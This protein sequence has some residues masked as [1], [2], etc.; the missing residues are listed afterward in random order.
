MY[1]PNAFFAILRSTVVLILADFLVLLVL[2]AAETRAGN[3][4]NGEN[5]SVVLKSY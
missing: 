2:T 5:A 1:I 4:E 3:P